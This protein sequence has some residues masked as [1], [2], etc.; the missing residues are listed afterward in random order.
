MVILEIAAQG[1]RGLTLPGGR[2]AL[3]AGYNVVAAD[4]AVLRRLLEALLWPDPRDAETVPRASSGPGG[5]GVRAGLTVMGSDGLTYRLVRDLAGG[6]QLHRFDAERR[7]FSLVSQDLAGI[8]RYLLGP[9]GLPERPRFS[10]LLALAASELPSKQPTAGLGGA[11]GPAI[12]ARKPLT[13]EQARKRIA[14]L[15]AELVRAQSADKLQYRLDG[16]QSRLFKLEEQLRSGEKIREGL[17][18]A[19][20]ALRELGPL[21]EALGRLGD[22]DVRLAAFEKAAAR[23]DEAL[24]RVAEERQALE[25]E[26]ARGAPPPFW[27]DPRFLAGAGAGLAA[28]VAGAAG[29][30]SSEPGLRYLAL[31]DLPASG[32]AAW[33]ALRWVGEIEAGERSGRRRKV[34]EERERKVLEQYERDTA[35]VRAV[36]KAQ[37]FS[38]LADLREAVGRLAD[39]QSVAAEWRRRLAELETEPGSR[40]AR[41]ERDRVQA[42]IQ[43]IE[44][45]LASEA[46][47]YVREPRSIEAEIARVEAEAAA[48]PAPAVAAAP[49]PQP[50]PGGGDALRGLLERAA[51]ELGTSPAGAVRA[52]QKRLAEVVPLLSAQRL[53]GC[54]ADDRGNVVVRTA[55]RAVPSLTLPP[56]DRDLI[57]LA[58]KLAFAE[59]SLA[60]TRCTAFFEDAFAGLP[61]GVRRAA[62]RLLKQAARSAQILHATGDPVF[63]EAADHST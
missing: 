51:R 39:A 8:A 49:A 44:E 53:D 2:A 41:E 4:G 17:E 19:E 33:T 5:A 63:R 18:A 32:Y 47:G 59:Q 62:A 43:T 28:L 21:S 31:L 10:A 60:A 14:E 34:V 7:S 55:G 24:A 48:P 58:L 9:V 30:G 36:M 20:A 6:C 56:A 26:A 45:Q 13:A 37:G 57:F 40:S 12:P 38:A 22:V 50:P 54:V 35:E 15:K 46:G 27:K 42:E 61:D 3:R 29:R 1:V 11:G 25:G 52:V 16:L 23:R